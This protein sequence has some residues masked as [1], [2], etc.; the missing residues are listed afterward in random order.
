MEN[1]NISYIKKST[2]GIYGL[3]NFI[4][5]YK[6]VL[7]ENNKVVSSDYES[8]IHE[9]KSEIKMALLATLLTNNFDNIVDNLDESIKKD[10]INNEVLNKATSYLSF[11][12]GSPYNFGAGLQIISINR[13]QANDYTKILKNI[14][15]GIAHSNYEYSD[16]IIYIDNQD[17]KATM[18]LE[19]LEM[20]VLVLFSNRN[21]TKKK[22]SN[23]IF[24]LSAYNKH[25][26][27]YYSFNECLN[28]IDEYKLELTNDTEFSLSSHIAGFTLAFNKVDMNIKVSQRELLIK[29]TNKQMKNSFEISL[30]PQN[31]E[32]IKL[33]EPFMPYF[34]AIK[35]DASQ[36][37]IIA[38]LK[39]IT[40]SEEKR[41]TLAYKNI[42]E[43][44]HS[45]SKDDV[46][47]HNI[48]GK[49]V[50]Y[51]L[52]TCSQLLI[53][54]YSNIIFNFA[55]IKEKDKELSL[56]KDISFSSPNYVSIRKQKLKKIRNQLEKGNHGEVQKLKLEAKRLRLVSEID[57][58]NKFSI[59]N[60]DVFTRLRNSV[61]HDNIE[62]K[63]LHSS[64]NIIFRD[65]ENKILNFKL[66]IK[67]PRLR[68]FAD[69]TLKT[70]NE[71]VKTF[72]RS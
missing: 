1:K 28:S 17:F 14:R 20:M 44:L 33:L 16:G 70:L 71:P 42:L 63:P 8:Y 61:I 18:T 41:N 59:N 57:Q 54:S 43:L 55:R 51:Y 27:D 48:F 65:A 53:K 19:W 5:Q 37:R 49:D 21:Q 10:I 31:E 40:S 67:E 2:D 72:I 47:V 36:R 24:L 7:L 60:D 30:L 68:Q 6:D 3:L 64:D 50:T 9:N 12:D 66:A 11:E 26:Y 23:D 58:F 22:G 38:N 62:F 46:D 15:N 13:K 35:D 56:S 52:T 25:V 34:F 29:K 32:F 4:E 69:E 39:A 45:I